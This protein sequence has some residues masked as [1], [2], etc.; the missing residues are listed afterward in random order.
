MGRWGILQKAIFLLFLFLL[1]SPHPCMSLDA[2][3]LD[4]S[5][6]GVS[7]GHELE[8]VIENVRLNF[9]SEIGTA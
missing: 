2:Q 1:Y 7:T 9:G 3:R 6:S 8:V 5:R 4:F